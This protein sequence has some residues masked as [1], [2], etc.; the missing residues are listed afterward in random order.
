MGKIY[1]YELR[2]LTLNKLFFGLLVI[3]A[4]YCWNILTN[5]TILGTAH[6]AP[7][8]AWSFGAY[9]AGAV[10]LI[11][12]G[13]LLS[14]TFFA[15]GSPDSVSALTSATPVD[16]RKYLLVRSGAVLTC[17][18]IMAICALALAFGFYASVFGGA[19][20]IDYGAM[21]APAL[22]SLPPALLFFLGAG[23]LA[24][25]T[26]PALVYALMIPALAMSGLPR[27]WDP[28]AGGFFGEYPLTLGVLDPGFTLPAYALS[29]RAAYIAA[30][31]AMLLL[32]MR[33]ARRRSKIT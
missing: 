27:G 16:A 18:A 15:S 9:I 5:V 6:T 23:W 17:S 2:R 13:E 20:H 21:I 26:R 32:A 30:G 11:C 10:P 14:L 12:I 4:V 3:L 19:I 22:I 31:A 7:F 25:Q 29:S 33:Y 24:A 8:S 1:G 28:A